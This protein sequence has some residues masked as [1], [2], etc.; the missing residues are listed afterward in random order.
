M[1]INLPDPVDEGRHQFSK[2]C[3]PLSGVA[4]VAKSHP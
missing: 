3:A 2:K 4:S 1:R